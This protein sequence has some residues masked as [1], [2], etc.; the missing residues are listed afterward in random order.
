MYKSFL[1]KSAERL[2]QEAKTD[3]VIIIIIKKKL[4]NMKELDFKHLK[5]LAEYNLQAKFRE[6]RCHQPPHTLS[7]PDTFEDLTVQTLSSA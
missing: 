1:S 2:L 3:S 6:K 4:C 7:T 5:R